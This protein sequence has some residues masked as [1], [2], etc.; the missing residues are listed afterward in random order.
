M[1]TEKENTMSTI[2]DPRD[3][4]RLDAHVDRLSIAAL[5]AANLYPDIAW[6]DLISYEQDEVR[7]AVTQAIRAVIEEKD[8]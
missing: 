7:E 3:R 2:P 4:D 6:N 5:N 1:T 8:A